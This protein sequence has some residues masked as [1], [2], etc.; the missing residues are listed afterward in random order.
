MVELVLA[1]H[2]RIR[3][4]FASLDRAASLAPG[5]YP[6]LAGPIWAR[7]SEVITLHISREQEI[8]YLAMFTRYGHRREEM[9]QAVADLDRIREAIQEASLHRCGCLPWWMS[10]LAAQRVTDRHCDVVEHTGLAALRAGSSQCRSDLGRR[11]AVFA[12]GREPCRAE[13]S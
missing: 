12:A 2:R 6:H 10:V 13:P 5:P 11:W 1:E 4:L 7:L 9:A 8:C 3:R